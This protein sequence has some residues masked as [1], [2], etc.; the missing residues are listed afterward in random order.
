[1]A[2]QPPNTTDR[3]EQHQGGQKMKYRRGYLGQYRLAN[4]GQRLLS[5]AI[6]FTAA[7]TVPAVVLYLLFWPFGGPP[8]EL[9]LLI[10]G[11]LYGFNTI[12]LQG[13]TG[14][15]LGKA[16]LGLKLVRPV[17]EEDGRRWLA[18]PGTGRCFRREAAHMVDWIGFPFAIGALRLFWN[19][20]RQSFADSMC[21][22]AVVASADVQLVEAS[23]EAEDL[24]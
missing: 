18:L 2:P 22:T 15:T 10:I 13:V 21:H 14:Q 6:D 8:A 1:M 12:V 4:A 16:V 11:L 23:L 7:V 19:P 3:S 5:Y 17:I 9:V 24:T 20:R